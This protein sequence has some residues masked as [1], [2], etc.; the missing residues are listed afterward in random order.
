MM[1][2][3]MNI[4]MAETDEYAAFWLPQWPPRAVGSQLKL[5]GVQRRNPT[6]IVMMDQHTLNTRAKRANILTFRVGKMLRSIMHMLTFSKPIED[7]Y[8]TK[9]PKSVFPYVGWRFTFKN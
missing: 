1:M 9:E 4:S 3:S 5:K 2:R 8:V 6:S 7:A